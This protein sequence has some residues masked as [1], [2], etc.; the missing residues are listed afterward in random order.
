MVGDAEGYLH[1]L[2]QSDGRF[3][4]RRKA[5]AGLRSPL[6]E[7]DDVVYVLANDGSLEALEIERRS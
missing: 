7:V 3:L 5:S 2:A 1:V 4:A 6:L